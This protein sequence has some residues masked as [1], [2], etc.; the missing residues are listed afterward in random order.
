MNKRVLINDVEIKYGSLMEI[1]DRLDFF[2][3]FKFVPA[4]CIIE[5]QKW[6]GHG[7]GHDPPFL[8]F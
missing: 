6:E 5:E 7:P 4:V 1:D 2:K 8:K 3:V